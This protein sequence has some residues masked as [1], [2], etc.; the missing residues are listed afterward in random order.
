L[1]INEK[2][3][4]YLAKCTFL[5]KEYHKYVERTKDLE[6]RIVKH[7]QNGLK[8]RPGAFGPNSRCCF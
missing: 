6:E 1:E 7:K 3:I 2:H 8:A 4:I 5:G